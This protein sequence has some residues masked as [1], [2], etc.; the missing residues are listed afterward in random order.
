MGGMMSG[1]KRFMAQKTVWLGLVIMILIIALLGLAILGSTVNPVPRDLPV[2]LVVADKGVDIPGRGSIRIGEQLRE[3]LVAAQTPTGEPS[4]FKWTVLENEAEAVEGLDRQRY[5]A[6]IVL[7]DNLSASFGSLMSP[8]PQPAEVRVLVNQ[9]KSAVAATM[10]TQAVGNMMEGINTQLREQALAQIQQAQGGAVSVAQAKAL[11]APLAATFE[12]VH[13]IVRNTANGNAPV[14][15]T[16][17]AWMAALAA[18]ALLHVTGSKLGAAGGSNSGGWAVVCSTLVAGAIYAVVAAGAI[19]FIPNVLFGLEIPDWSVTFLFLLLTV[20]SF[21]L[22]QTAVVSW[23]G[24]KGMPILVLLFFFGLPILSLPPEFLPTAAKEWLYAWIPF[25]FSV[26]GLRDL[27]YF[28]QG[29]NVAEPAA[30]LGWIGVAGAALMILTV[31]KRRR[32][33]RVAAGSGD[34]AR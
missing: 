3:K 20:F 23:I 31:S 10:I 17:L 4:P 1:M 16:Q 24:L 15:L 6:A 32:V 7:P 14:V 25:R 21:F 29:L 19:L 22:L 33:A 28:R 13:P 2:A 12:A 9:G 11:A 8:A 34:A 5:Y 30:I 27:F 18:C 26:E